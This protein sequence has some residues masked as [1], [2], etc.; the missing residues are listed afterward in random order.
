MKR[1]VVEAAEAEAA[2]I[3]GVICGDNM[4]TYAV[5]LDSAIMIPCHA[6]LHVVGAEEE[7]AIM[8]VYARLRLLWTAST[9]G[10]AMV[11]LLTGAVWLMMEA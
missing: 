7:H 10:N 3:P 2:V 8:I 6:V 4:L 1:D 9:A 5:Q 11:I